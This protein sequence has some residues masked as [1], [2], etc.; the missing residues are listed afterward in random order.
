VCDRFLELRATGCIDHGFDGTSA[1]IL[2]FDV[3]GHTAGE[4]PLQPGEPPAMRFNIRNTLLSCAIVTP[5]SIH[6]PSI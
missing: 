4:C 5:G 1:E 6:K 3:K 2:R